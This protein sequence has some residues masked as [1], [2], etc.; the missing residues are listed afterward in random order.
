MQYKFTMQKKKKEKNSIIRKFQSL[1]SKLTSHNQKLNN[2]V[3]FFANEVFFL[4]ITS[5]FN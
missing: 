2:Y 4:Q 3:Q 1:E 5:F